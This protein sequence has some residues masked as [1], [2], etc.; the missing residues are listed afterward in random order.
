MGKIFSLLKKVFELFYYYEDDK[1][2]GV[3]YWTDPTLIGG[4]VSL[5]SMALVNYFSI[6]IP[7]DTQLKISGAI[8]GIG[9]LFSKHSGIVVKTKSKVEQKVDDRPHNLT[10]LY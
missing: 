4:V 9:A 1:K 5:I 8:V 6:D 3:T 2:K 7:L 10:G